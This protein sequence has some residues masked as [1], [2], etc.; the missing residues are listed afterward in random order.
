MVSIRLCKIACG[1]YQES[2][3]NKKE[4]RN[5][6]EICRQWCD[7]ECQRSTKSWRIQERCRSISPI[8]LYDSRRRYKN[9]GVTGIKEPKG[10]E[11]CISETIPNCKLPLS[12][13]DEVKRCQPATKKM[14]TYTF[15]IV[16]SRHPMR[17]NDNVVRVVPNAPI[18]SAVPAPSDLGLPRLAL[19]CLWIRLSGSISCLST[20]WLAACFWVVLDWPFETLPGK[21][22]WCR[23]SDR[24]QFRFYRGF[25][26]LHK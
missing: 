18:A 16:M 26:P 4:N 8:G 13:G 7:Q 10:T 6:D 25:P 12:N 14:A 20:G 11:N 23:K 5:V 17:D 2:Q 21:D 3:I 9:C 19:C 24:A 15:V 1:N 22:I